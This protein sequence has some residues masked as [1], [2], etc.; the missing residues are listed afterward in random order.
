MVETRAQMHGGP[1]PADWKA[2]ATRVKLVMFVVAVAVALAL[3]VL[4]A[5]RG[6]TRRGG[7]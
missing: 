7:S 3:T 4:V 1:Y 2:I 5:V 6:V